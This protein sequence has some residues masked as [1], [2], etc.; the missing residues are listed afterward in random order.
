MR[1]GDAKSF[2]AQQDESGGLL[3]ERSRQLEESFERYSAFTEKGENLVGEAWDLALE[4]EQVVAKEPR[5]LKLLSKQWEADLLFMDRLTSQVVAG[6]VCF[7]SSWDL[8][9]AIGKTLAEV[10]GIVPRLNPQIGEMIR[11][12]LEKL[13][14]G[15]SYCRENWSFTRSDALDYHPDLNRQRLDETLSLDEVYL[16][17]EHQIFTGLSDGVLMGIRIETTPLKELA[18]DPSV[19][20]TT[21]EKLRTMPDD[22]ARYKSMD[23]AIPTILKE[24]K[25]YQ[26]FQ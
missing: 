24:M 25:A 21:A 10:H 8:R 17:I 2:F 23:A 15:K 14:P 16:R 3:L 13:E 22:V 18:E 20:N 7:P 1:K 6:S 4:W 19:W 26:S 9:H 5:N 11:R 12:F